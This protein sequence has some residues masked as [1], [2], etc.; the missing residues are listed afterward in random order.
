VRFVVPF[1]PGGATDILARILGQYLSER[2]G[3]QV[4]IENKPGGGTNIAVALVVKAPPDGY[5]MLMTLTTNTINPWLYKSLPFDFARDIALVSG[6]AEQPLILVAHPGVP[7]KTVPE[8][9]AHAKANPGKVIFGS[10]GVRTVSHLSI[11]L[12]KLSTGIEVVHVPYP[13]GAPMLTDLIAGRIH[14]GIDALPNSLGHVRSGAVRGLAVLSKARAPTLPDVPSISETVPDIEVNTWVGI[15][16]PKDTP[17]EIVG[18]LNRAINASLAH[19]ALKARYADVGSVPVILT[20]AEASARFARDT[21]NWGKVV[22]RAGL[23]AE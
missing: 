23:K 3:Q 1:P 9:V 7:G 6:I 12:I 5:T 21:E 20:P 2:L 18:H 16:V 22:Q 15:G 11:E 8:F 13:G 4:V 10:F 19:P 17:A 14:A